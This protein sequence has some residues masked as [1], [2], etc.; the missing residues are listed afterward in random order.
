MR[1]LATDLANAQGALEV[2]IVVTVTPHRPLD[3]KVQRDGA[4]TESISIAQSQE[5]EANTE[6]EIAM[7]GIVT[8]GVR[9]GRREAQARA[10]AL[11]NRWNQ[12][13]ATRL[14]AAG[15]ADL[16]GLTAKVSDA[17]DLDAGIRQKDGDLMSLR[18]QIVP[19]YVAADALRQ[20]TDHLKACRAAIGEV[21]FDPLAADLS[22]LGA[23]AAA[24][25]ARRRQQLSKDAEA[26]RAFAKQAANDHAI[27]EERTRQLRSARDSA[28]SSRDVALKPF[29]QGV[30][31]ALVAAQAEHAARVSENLTIAMELASL[32]AKIEARKKRIE[33]AQRDARAIA[34]KADAAVKSAEKE[35]EVAMTD[36]ASQNGRLIELRKLRDAGNLALAGDKLREA[37]EYYNALPVPDR[38]VS[39][40]EVVAAQATVAVLKSDLDAIEREIHRAHGALEQVGGAVARE[41][42]SDATDAFELAERQER[43]IEAE[44]EAWKLLLEQMKEA[45]AAQASNLGLS[46]VPAI[47]D[48]F[49]HLTRQRYQTVKL[50][51]QLATE[52]V[53]VAGNLRSASYLSVGTR[54]QLSTLFRLSLAEYLH[55]AIVLDDQLVQSDG[56]RMDWFRTLLNEKAHTFQVIVLTCRPSDYL[57]PAA[58]VP[59]GSAV[60][61]DMD[62]EPIRAIDLERALRRR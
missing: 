10:A 4:G 44:Y 26:A 38:I 11:E 28:I 20:A 15:V 45:D 54:E 33:A 21:E 13:V 59:D 1:K 58:L 51:A 52:G 40:D 2:G 49:N 36:Q 53:V 24:K 41:R 50:S 3:L 27:A 31:A 61:A 12:E 16:D 56:T 22:A 48:Q 9:G 6:L 8:F 35:L 14:L 42:L 7:A 5:I 62:G 60:Y 43:E 23:D 30:D 34:E 19:L 18:E 29:P 57:P 32:D 25:L 17:Q 39:D 46:L 37:T 47:A 55:T